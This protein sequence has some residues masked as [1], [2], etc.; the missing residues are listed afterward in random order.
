[1]TKGSNVTI[2]LFGIP[3]HRAGIGEVVV[4]PGTIREALVSLQ[5]TCPNLRDLIRDGG[6]APQYLLS[7]DGLSFIGDLN[8]VLA[9]GSHLILL[10]ADVGG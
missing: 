10:S 1:M 3:R 4:A 7:V 9:P 2:E 8:Q 6:L 5:Q